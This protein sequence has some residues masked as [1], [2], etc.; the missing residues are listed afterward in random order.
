MSVQGHLPGAILP[1]RPGICFF[2]ARAGHPGAGKGAKWGPATDPPEWS[3]MVG[4]ERG[5]N[6]HLLPLGPFTPPGVNYI[7]KKEVPEFQKNR[8][9]FTPPGNPTF[10]PISGVA[11]P[12][13]GCIFWHIGAGNGLG[14][15]G[16]PQSRS[17]RGGAPGG[18]QGT[19]G[20]KN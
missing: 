3:K 12:G 2:G 7:E 13:S 5:V 8:R 17:R 19:A 16:P 15:I 10:G 14:P 6:G 11:G 18:N 4:G 9:K 20:W 1:C